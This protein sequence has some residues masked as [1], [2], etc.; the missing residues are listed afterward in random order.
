MLTKKMMIQM[1]EGMGFK[2]RKKMFLQ[3]LE[4]LWGKIYLNKEE[5]VVLAM[6]LSKGLQLKWEMKFIFDFLNFKNILI[7]FNYNY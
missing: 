2:K 7:I 5:K 6:L 1:E 3:I 4:L